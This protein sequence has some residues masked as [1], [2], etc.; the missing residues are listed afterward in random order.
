M[1]RDTRQ[2]DRN[3][4]GEQTTR[5]LAVTCA[6]DE[7]PCLVEWVAH[8][9]ALGV[10]DFLVFTNECSDGTVEL[11]RALAPVGVVQVDNRAP[12]GK[13]V[14]WQALKSAWAHPLR[15][16]C[17]WALVIDTDEF[18]NLRA[19]LGSLSD[20]GAASGGADAM[21]LPWRLYGHNGQARIGG[22]L[23]IETFT[24]AAPPGCQYP[25]AACQ[26]KTMFRLSGPFARFGVHRPRLK[27]GKSALWADGSG[28]PMEAAF[29]AAED[30]INLFGREPASAHVE[31]AHYSVRSAEAFMLKCLRGLPNRKGKPLDLTY[32]VERNFNTVEDRSMLNHLD[33]TRAEVDALMTLPGVAELHAQGLAWHRARFAELMTDRAMVQFYGRLL[34]AASSQP[35][36][37]AAVAALARAYGAAD[38]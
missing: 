36:P 15:K 30:R 29:A 23:T 26:F 31:L 2:P 1:N 21:V 38:G 20:L 25:V 35:L 5:I 18:V 16:S 37:D 6:R 19:P 11:A 28:L 4:A 10:T 8:H 3:G 13:S 14:Q 33:A 12:P 17:D 32:W 22:G 27:K 24:R 34:L 9:R 7:A